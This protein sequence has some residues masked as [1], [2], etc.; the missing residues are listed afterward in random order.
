MAEVPSTQHP[1]FL[2]LGSAARNAS[3][4]RSLLAEAL[5]PGD[6]SFF[7]SRTVWGLSILVAV[8][9]ARAFGPP[10]GTKALPGLTGLPLGFGRFWGLPTNPAAAARFFGALHQRYGPIYQWKVFGVTS[11]WISSDKIAQELLGQRGVKYGDRQQLL[12]T[13]GLY[14][15][16]DFLPAMA[17]GPNA[18]RHAKFM[19]TIMKHSA[20]Q[21]FYGYPI[22]EVKRTL[23]RLLH[24]PDRWSE[25]LV[26]H[27]ARTAAA[28]A[29]GDPK[30]ATK[31]LQVVPPLVK[32]ASTDSL[33]IK[34]LDSLA[35]FPHWLS[36]YSN[37][38]A[39][40]KKD[41][42]D[43]FY[44]AQQEV[45]ERVT[46]GAASES[47]TRIWL[48]NVGGAKESQLDQ[49]EAAHAVGTAAFMT[50]ATNA[51]PLHTFFAAISQHPQWLK[52]LQ[53]EVDRVCPE[54]PPSLHQMSQL[55]VLRAV[56]KECMRWQPALPLGIAHVTTADDVYD[57]YF[58]AKGTVVQVNHYAISRDPAMYP[59][60]NEFRPERWLEP[61]WPSYKA[62]ASDHPTLQ[63]DAAF[64]YGLRGCPGVDLTMVELYSLIGALVWAFDIKAKSE[65]VSPPEATPYIISMPRPFPCV[66]TPRSERKRKVIEDGCKDMGVVVKE[67]GKSASRWDVCREENGE[68]HWQGLTVPRR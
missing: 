15:G 10:A 11:I 47:W 2:G 7:R 44:E 14:S 17:L 5:R 66:I 6:L 20:Q 52:Q 28:C 63:G 27:C 46:A 67:S 30:H 22:D 25:Q 40:R 9:L 19:H 57:G 45:I 26:T 4:A 59:Q 33:M 1:G 48:E 36:P 23:K 32:A 37:A 16:S 43:A 41:M 35:L 42:R 3:F 50:L 56:I 18:S 51:A 38:E 64:G 39:T 68:F 34:F 21:H 65:S 29:W 58:I 54:H 49:H 53:Q 8:L 31:L 55:P 60:P 12:S 61:S 24:N 62:P 13:P